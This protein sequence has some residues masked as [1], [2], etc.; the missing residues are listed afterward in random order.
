MPEMKYFS[1][2]L[3]FKPYLKV[4]LILKFAFLM[5]DPLLVPILCDFQSLSQF[6]WSYLEPSKPFECGADTHLDF[7]LVVK[8]K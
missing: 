8:V 5:R 7:S 4:H 6:S 3:Q 1:L 2:Q